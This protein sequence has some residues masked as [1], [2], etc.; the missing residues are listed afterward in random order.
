MLAVFFAA[1]W[2]LRADSSFLHI[3]AQRPAAESIARTNGLSL[4]D[5]LALRDL[6]GVDAPQIEWERAAA[7]FA[8]SRGELG[9]PLAATALFHPEQAVE[10]RRAAADP[11]AAWRA[12]AVHE[13]AVHGLRFLAMRERFGARIPASD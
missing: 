3:E 8:G 12:F 2:L 5:V 4:A 13:H 6:V 1:F 10:A 9:D 7:S 11:A